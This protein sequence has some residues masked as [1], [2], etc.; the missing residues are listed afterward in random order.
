MKLS[1]SMILE[2]LEMDPERKDLLD[3]PSQKSLKT[4]TSKLLYRKK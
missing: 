1:C 4:F 2:L 3:L